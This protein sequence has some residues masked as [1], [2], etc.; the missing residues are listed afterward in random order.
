MLDINDITVRFGGRVL[1]NEVSAHISDGQKVG[2]VGRNGS[3]KST[4]FRVILSAFSPDSGE[5]RL[6]KGHRIATVAQ[7]VP[8]GEISLLDCVLQAD[9]ER[10]TLLAELETAE[11]AEDGI[12]I[13]EIHERL[14]TIGANSAVARA[15]AI[16]YGL[17]FSTEEQLRPVSTFSGGWRM[18][19]ALAAA[20]FVPSEVLLLDEPTNHLDLEAALWLENYLSHYTGTLIIISHDRSLLNNLCTRIINIENARLVSYSGNYDTFEKTRA[21]QREAQEK[22]A[23]KT[24]EQRK[25]LQDFVDRFRYKA[26]KAKQAQSRIKMLERLGP[27][28][29]F[30]NEET[31][32]FNFPSPHELP[33][34]LLKIEDGVAGYDG[35][36]VLSRLNLRIDSDDRIALIGANGNG[37]STLAKVLSN[38]LALMSG[39]KQASNKLQVGYFA[40]HQT[41]ELSRNLTAFQ[42]AQLRMPKSNE[43]QIRAHLGAFGLTQQKADTRIEKLSG[44]EKSRLLFALMSR[45]APHILILDEPTNHL[46]M[47]A[48]DALIEALNLYKGAVILITHDPHLIELTADRLWLVANGTCRSYDGD[49]AD[50]RAML[51]QNNRIQNAGQQDKTELDGINSA[52]ARKDERRQAA[53][54]RQLQAPLRKKLKE[55][56]SKI[57]KLTKEKQITQKLLEDPSL[58][59]DSLNSKKISMLQRSMARFNEEIQELET[60]WMTISEQLED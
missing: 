50:Y 24:E 36:A 47:D 34:P 13:G 19:V 52:A 28:T 6:T 30:I 25:H 43:T 1:F 45:D 42:Q 29:V 16:L 49:L 40:Q 21:I 37:K 7:E 39:S 51:A 53:E 9:T 35:K 3:G 38:R 54:R 22:H 33:P 8:E 31:A 46:D 27:A 12:R 55:I 56:E 23:A 4:L 17:G 2:L 11:N 26:S 20:L 5:V 32:R 14:N 59:A 60:S 18:R 58:Y 44:G 15:G 48:R 41:D 10:T 57:D